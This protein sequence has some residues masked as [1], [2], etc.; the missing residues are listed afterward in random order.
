MDDEPGP[1]FIHIDKGA[2]AGSFRDAKNQKNV[3]I[4]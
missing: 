4:E 3:L 2:L 1:P